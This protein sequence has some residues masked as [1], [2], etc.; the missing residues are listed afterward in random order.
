MIRRRAKIA[1]TCEGEDLVERQG[2]VK[3]S[4]PGVLVVDGRVDPRVVAR[5][6][7]Q[8]G[9]RGGKVILVLDEMS[10]TEV[11]RDTDTLEDGGEGH[12]GGDVGIGAISRRLV[13]RLRRGKAT[14][15]IRTSRKCRA[16]EPCRRGQSRGRRR[17][18]PRG[19]RSPGSAREPRSRSQHLQTRPRQTS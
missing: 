18:Q 14:E 1:F 5:L 12:K 6:G 15:K 13:S 7:G 2:S 19:R 16:W 8:D 10:G 17:G 4:T 9:T 3:G 11:G